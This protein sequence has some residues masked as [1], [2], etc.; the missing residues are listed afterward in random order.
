MRNADHDHSSS[1]AYASPLDTSDE[2]SVKPEDFT[3]ISVDYAS[4][5][6]KNVAYQIPA[7]LPACPEAGVGACP[8]ASVLS[9]ADDV[10]QCLVSWSWFHAVDAGSQQMF[11]LVYRAKVTGA[12][13]AIPL[14]QREY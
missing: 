1:H 10:A 8:A 9:F 6:F 14:P 3:V 12:T 13:N 2:N 5:W 11:H 4:P 7:D